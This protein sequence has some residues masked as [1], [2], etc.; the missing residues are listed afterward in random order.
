MV[1][2]VPA[3]VALE[4]PRLRLRCAEPRDAEALAG[5]MSEAVSR[6]L[7][8]WP[9][10]YTP[11]MALDRIAGVRMAA[12]ERRSL[13]LVIER[14]SDGAVLGW[15]SISR[16]PG[17]GSTALITYWL[18]EGFQ[19]QGLMREAAPAAL[20]EAFRS[21]DVVRV[22][23]AVQAD[24]AASLAVVRLLGLAPLGEGRIWCPARGRD[25]P[26]LWFEIGREAAMRPHEDATVQVE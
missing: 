14:R 13:P 18:G 1:V 26:C 15:I 10:P 12:A 8:S 6:R 20:A 22:R 2:D 11:L 21:M 7:A 23:A 16:A 5:M 9:V 19:G 17:D 24:N 3:L 4:T 25:E